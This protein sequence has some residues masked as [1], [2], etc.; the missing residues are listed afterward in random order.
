MSNAEHDPASDLAAPLKSKI[1]H[2]LWRNTGVGGKL[3]SVHFSSGKKRPDTDFPPSPDVQRGKKWSVPQKTSLTAQQPRGASPP[4]DVSLPEFSRFLL[5]LKS[6][7]FQFPTP[8]RKK[9]CRV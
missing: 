8:P 7:P 2:A 9:V 3:M 4:A 6:I 1:R 5:S